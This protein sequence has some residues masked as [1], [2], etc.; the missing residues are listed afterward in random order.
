MIGA[1]SVF[2]FSVVASQL[3]T[4][5]NY[6]SGD[7]NVVSGVG[8]A[9]LYLPFLFIGPFY[10]IAGPRWTL[11]LAIVTYSGGYLLL[12][13]AYIGKIAGS[14]LAVSVYY[15]IVG[16][17]STAAYMA[18]IGVNVG[19]FTPK[20]AGKVTGFLH[21]FYAIAGSIYSSIFSTY[22]FTDVPGYIVFLA[23]S[24]G[25]T[26]LLS[27]VTLFQVP[28]DEEKKVCVTEE[29][30][31]IT[32][33]TVAPKNSDRI[34]TI[35]SPLEEQANTFSATSISPISKKP[36]YR[37]MSPLIHS[38]H[39]SVR[40]LR[41]ATLSPESKQRPSGSTTNKQ[42]QNG[43]LMAKNDKKP[44]NLSQVFSVDSLV[45]DNIIIES[46]TALDIKEE[47][48]RKKVKFQE[49]QTVHKKRG[50]LDPN[51][52]RNSR[53]TTSESKYRAGGSTQI[54]FGSLQWLYDDPKSK[55]G[56]IDGKIHP[57]SRKQTTNANT[58]KSSVSFLANSKRTDS[59]RPHLPG[60]HNAETVSTM[61]S[62]KKAVAGTADGEDSN[63]TLMNPEMTS[64]WDILKSPVF[65]LYACTCIFQQGTV[66]MTN[67]GT[68]LLSTYGQTYTTSQVDNMTLTHVTFMSMF[69]AGAMFGFGVLSDFLESL[70]VVWLDRTALM[71][72]SQI[73]LLFPVVAL[74]TSDSSASTLLFCSICTGLGFGASSCLLPILTQDF[75]GLQFFGTAVGFAMTGVPIGILV[76]NSVFGALNDQQMRAQGSASA[77]YGTACYQKSFQIFTGIQVVAVATS[78]G[79][80]ILRLRQRYGHLEE[81]KK[82]T[83]MLAG[84]D[85]TA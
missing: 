59:L 19:N 53:P 20:A 33:I 31:P 6:S 82:S 18:V 13:A 57:V 49:T 38:N 5:F 55:K 71:F 52:A 81:H 67:V 64:A 11:L 62:L 23:Y 73:V 4:Q 12:W 48:D 14:V 47:E 78:L 46:M 9:A 58:S 40:S 69:Q 24:V 65:W 50:S 83:S 28:L 68:I 15:F 36:N 56:T 84:L 63:D 51:K 32:V 66:Y 8:F 45:D 75:F 72:I 43:R 21:L 39:N 7:L 37:D 17:G 10:D 85:G 25:L 26:A 30:T 77:C 34:A 3:Q 44:S 76:C 54:L 42:A 61:T 22:Y 16:I 70:K 41:N 29:Q 79:L 80:L 60:C 1:G 2:A 27:V 35:G 74:S